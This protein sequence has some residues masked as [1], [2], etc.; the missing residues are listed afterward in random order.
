[1]T[2]LEHP[3]LAYPAPPTANFGNTLATNVTLDAA[4]EKFAG[5]MRWEHSAALTEVYFRSISAAVSGTLEIRIETV[6]TSTG[7]PTGTLVN[8]NASGQVVVSAANTFYSVT[9]TSPADVHLLGDNELFAVVLVNVS[10]EYVISGNHSVHTGTAL[11]YTADYLASTWVKRVNSP[12]FVF[13]TASGFVPIT[14]TTPGILVASLIASNTTPDEQGL[15]FTAP[16]GMRVRGIWADDRRAGP[17]KIILYNA[18][19]GVLQ[20]ITLAAAVTGTTGVYGT[21]NYIF[22]DYEDIVQGDTYRVTAQPTTT[23]ANSHGLVYTILPTG[24][25]D[26]FRG[27]NFGS[28][29][30]R[31]NGGAWTDTSDRVPLMGLLVSGI[32]FPDG[33]AGIARLV[34]AGLVG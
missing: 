7:L 23:T 19:D 12:P 29:T 6:D 13:E 34:G 22:N 24:A 8:A 16:F 15:V 17:Y 4:G 5:I 3:L 30:E 21:T 27:A 11:P 1:M 18:A 26:A 33:G 20:E 32:D 28:W 2:I 14:G 9:L 25:G 10:G 31:T